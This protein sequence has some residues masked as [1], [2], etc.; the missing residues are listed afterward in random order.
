MVSAL[1]LSLMDTAVKVTPSNPLATF[2][3]LFRLR[4]SQTKSVI[5]TMINT[6]APATAPA[7]R[8]VFNL[9]VD[10]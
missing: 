9:F 8:D 6:T 10:G 1:I 3:G 2:S 4:R 7:K 5:T